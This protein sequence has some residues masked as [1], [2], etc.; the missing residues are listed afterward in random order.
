MLLLRALV[1]SFWRKPYHHKLVRWGTE[2]H[3]RFMLPHFVQEDLR[4]VCEYLQEQGFLFQVE[5]LAPFMDFRFPVYGRVQFRDVHIEL[6]TAIEPWHVLGEEL[7]NAGTARFVDSSLERLQVMV[8]GAAPGR[9]VLTCNGR[10]VPLKSTGTNSE[11]VAGIRYR[12]WQPPSC[13]HPTIGVHSPLVI[14]LVDTWTG[15]SIGGCTY[16]VMH[17]GGRNYEIFP[18]NSLEAE[19]RRIARFWGHGHTPGELAPPPEVRWRMESEGRFYP[20]GKA[21][22]PLEPPVE[23]SS[24][25]YPATLDLRYDTWRN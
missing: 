20:H 12:A 22:A 10:R 2:L 14:D 25:E 23:S 5:W 18:I 3:D 19:G 1:A 8:T 13:L 4:D 15:R 11:F 24:P 21:P 9:Y 17:P 16:H 6:R 7:T